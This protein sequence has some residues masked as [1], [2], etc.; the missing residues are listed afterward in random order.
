MAG[1]ALSISLQHCVVMLRICSV[2]CY[3]L[4]FHL[5]LRSDARGASGVALAI[6]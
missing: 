2:L 3:A 1:Q 4:A 6:F 5:R